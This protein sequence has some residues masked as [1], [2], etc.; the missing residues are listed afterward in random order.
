MRTCGWGVEGGELP[1]WGRPILNCVDRGRKLLYVD[2]RVPDGAFLFTSAYAFSQGKVVHL[3]DSMFDKTRGVLVLSHLDGWVFN[4]EHNMDFVSG[5]LSTDDWIKP[6]PVIY[7][8][9][10]RMNMV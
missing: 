5:T 9:I 8:G 7:L 10:M 4:A 2:V 6:R 3:S 1:L